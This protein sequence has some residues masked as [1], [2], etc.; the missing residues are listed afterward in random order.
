L[1]CQGAFFTPGLLIFDFPSHVYE[2]IL[3]LAVFAMA[4]VLNSRA[5]TITFINMTGCVYT[6]HV[7][8]VDPATPTSMFASVPISIPPAATAFPVPSSLPGL[9]TLPATVYYYFVRGWVNA[10]PTVAANVGNFP[11][12]GFPKAIV[13]PANNCHPQ[14]SNISFNG[15]STGGNVVVLIF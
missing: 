13:L 5:N 3:L 1:F 10:S 11:A 6:Y 8:G 9:S 2:K 7:V 15:N 4:C 12:S 14:P